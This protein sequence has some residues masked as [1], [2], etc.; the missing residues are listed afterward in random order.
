MAARDYGQLSTSVD[1]EFEYYLNTLFDM[2]RDRDY[3]KVSGSPIHYTFFKS[4]SQIFGFSAVNYETAFRSG[5]YSGAWGDEVDFWKPEAVERLR[6]RIRSFPEKIRWTSS[7]YGFNHVYEDFYVRKVGPIVNA[8]TYEN[9]TLSEAYFESL[10]QT[11]SHR[12]FQQE[13]LAKRINISEGGIY[14][15]FNAEVNVGSFP[16]RRGFPIWIGMDFNVNPMSAVVGQVIEDKLFIVDEIFLK[17][18]NTSSVAKHIKDKYGTNGITIVPDSTGVKTTSNSSRSD[19]DILKAEG[20]KVDST[21]NPFR[22]DRYAAV[23][24]ALEKGRLLVDNTCKNLIRDLEQVSFKA[25]GNQPD[26]SDAML[27]HISDALGYLVFKV[28]NPFR[29]NPQKIST[30]LR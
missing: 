2:K 13:V 3:K 6:G 24:I 7:P 27:G 12:L 10:K 1:R 9:P 23:N 28:I 5:S 8:S 22:I 26:T 11:Y 14:H 29:G 17:H 19:H 18:S 25:G 15:A 21:H 20:F 16:V 4:R 30:Q